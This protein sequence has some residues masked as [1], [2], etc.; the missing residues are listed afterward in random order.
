VIA[1]SDLRHEYDAHRVEVDKAVMRV[2]ESG[3][4]I[5]GQ[6][7][8][9]FEQEFAAWLGVPHAIG[10]GSG[11]EALHLALAACSIGPGDEVVTV[12][13]T[14]GATVAAIEPTFST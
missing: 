3:W 11:T 8:Q 1:C 4:C 5:L 2:L 6:E 7:V 10:A 13:H 12:S 14:A 9:R